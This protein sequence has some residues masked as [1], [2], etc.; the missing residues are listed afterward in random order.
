MVAF[1]LELKP[2][3]SAPWAKECVARFGFRQ[4]KP[5]DGRFLHATYCQ[6][7]RS[8]ARMHCVWEAVGCSLE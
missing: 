2:M 8:C 4:E 7:V 5:P 3:Y 1:A 6:P